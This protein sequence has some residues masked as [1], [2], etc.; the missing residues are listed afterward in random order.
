M[1]RTTG[2]HRE[3]TARQFRGLMF[4]SLLRADFTVL[5]RSGQ[6][7]ILNVA[8]PI[9]YLVI[10]NLHSASRRGGSI[11]GSPEFAI[12]LALT[13]GLMFSALMGY[14][15]AIARDRDM[16]VFQRLR[17]TPAPTWAIMASRFV[18]Q[19]AVGFAM[20]V[21]VVVVGG[22]LH[23]VVYDPVEYLLFAL[24]SVLGGAMFLAIGQAIVGLVSSFAVV[25]AI[26]RG[27]CIALLLLGLLGSSGILGDAVRSVADWTPVGALINLSVG[28]L[29]PSA[30]DW[31]ATSGLIATLGYAIV[32]VSIGIR[33]FRWESH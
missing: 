18:V 20:A 10:T 3:R 13:V 29:N 28:A 9:L 15:V 26:S 33:W 31:T 11:Y 5:L 27:I 4:S 1:T 6:T 24:V 16:G 21:I 23:S 14:S 32:G 19:L 30:W 22:I 8:V 2:A 12:G 7:L 25:N 17:V